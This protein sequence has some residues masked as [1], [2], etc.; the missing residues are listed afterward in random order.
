[1]EAPSPLELKKVGSRFLQM[2]KS[3]CRF[4][5]VWCIYGHGYHDLD[6]LPMLQVAI[7]SLLDRSIVMPLKLLL[8]V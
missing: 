3:P 5:R 8:G 2:I 1:M 4:T 7:G 6:P